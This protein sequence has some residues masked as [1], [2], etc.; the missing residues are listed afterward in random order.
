VAVPFPDRFDPAATVIQ[1]AVLS[2][3]HAHAGE[4]A[5]TVTSIDPPAAGLVAAAG[6][7]ANRHGAASCVMSAVASFT[8][9]M[10]WRGDGSTFSATRYDTAASPWPFPDDMMEIHGVGVDA[11]QVQSRFVLMVS[12]PEA[13]AA[14][15]DVIELATATEHFVPVGEV[16]EIDDDPQ[17]D[18]RY[19]S[20]V[21]QNRL[22]IRNERCCRALMRDAQNCKG[23][24]HVSMLIR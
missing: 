16:T 2:A 10:P 11:D 17:A 22:A 15:T 24:A 18:A 21:H 7:T 4:L 14:G 6:V 23:V 13:P 5:P 9:T 3:V 12:V 19:A 20:A 1:V 8:V